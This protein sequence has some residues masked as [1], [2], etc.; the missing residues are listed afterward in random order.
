MVHIVDYHNQYYM[1]LGGKLHRWLQE[2]G[3]VITSQMILEFKLN[4]TLWGQKRPD[5]VQRR[6]RTIQKVLEG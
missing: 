6:F 4:N 3:K 1:S 5:D 2:Q